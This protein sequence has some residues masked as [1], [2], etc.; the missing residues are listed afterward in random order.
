MIEKS[1]INGKD[2]NIDVKVIKNQI[3]IPKT[4]YF[5]VNQDFKAKGKLKKYT[6][7]KYVDIRKIYRKNDLEQRLELLKILDGVK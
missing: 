2:Y 5:G 1:T 6:K 4:W 7:S 3:I